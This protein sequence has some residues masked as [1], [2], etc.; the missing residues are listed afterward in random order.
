L[1]FLPG[2][3]GMETEIEYGQQAMSI[4]GLLSNMQKAKAIL[5]T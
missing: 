1:S 2:N 4:A 3:T 5:T